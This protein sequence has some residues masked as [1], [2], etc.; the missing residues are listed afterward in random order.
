MSQS[1]CLPVYVNCG[2]DCLTFRCFAVWTEECSFLTSLSAKAPCGS[3]LTETGS[4][5][6]DLS[7]WHLFRTLLSCLSQGQKQFEVSERPKGRNESADTYRIHFSVLLLRHSA[8]ANTVP[9]NASSQYHAYLNLWD[10]LISI[11]SIIARLCVCASA[12]QICTNWRRSHRIGMLRPGWRWM[13]PWNSALG[14]TGP[15]TSFCSLVMVGL[16]VH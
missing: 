4:L 12:E 11:H 8:H 10:Q 2:L 7:F 1:L 9:T 5:V 16:A 13:L 15:K 6:W 14:T 3:E